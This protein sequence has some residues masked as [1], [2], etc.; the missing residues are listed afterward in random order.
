M[1]EDVFV[2]F[3]L[4]D[5]GGKRLQ[6]GAASLKRNIM[7]K[8][9]SQ[10]IPLKG[11]HKLPCAPYE[12][13]GEYIKARL[14][15]NDHRTSRSTLR[16]RS[17]SFFDHRPSRSRS[18]KFRREEET[19]EVSRSNLTGDRQHFSVADPDRSV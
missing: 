8:P 9:F 12:G 2:E 1:Y 6:E 16:R 15:C 14:Y 7:P 19:K 5:V 4:L 3:N 13:P 10:D 17:R 18:R 11:P